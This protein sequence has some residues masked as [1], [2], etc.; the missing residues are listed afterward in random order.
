MRHSMLREAALSLPAVR[1]VSEAVNHSAVLRDRNID[2]AASLGIDQL[3][4]RGIV[5]GYSPPSSIVTKRSPVP[6]RG[7]V[8]RPLLWQ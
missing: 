4:G 1:V 3:D 8:L 5:S 2:A 6:S 7:A